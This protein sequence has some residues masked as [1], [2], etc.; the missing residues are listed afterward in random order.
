MNSKRNLIKLLI[1]AS[2][3]IEI[4]D[5]IIVENYD[6]KTIQEKIAFLKGMFDIECIGTDEL[7]ENTYWAMLETIR[8]SS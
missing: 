4:A 7:D 3:T 5:E 2:P 6:F 8:L 1:E